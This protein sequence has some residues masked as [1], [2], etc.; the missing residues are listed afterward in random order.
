MASA[1]VTVSC[2]TG[3][4]TAT[5]GTDG[6]FSVSITGGALP[7]VLTATS[8]DKSLE[9]HSLIP[10]TSSGSASATA[11]ITPLSELLIAKYAGTDPKAFVTGFT[12]T[13]AIK[14]SDITTAQTALLNTL[15]TAGVD[16]SKAADILAGTIVAGSK[17]DYDGVLEQLKTT[18]TN[19]GATLTDLSSAVQNSS[20]SS[21]TTT[22]AT[23]A[24]L[25][26]PAASDCPGL[27]T[28][29]LRVVNFNTTDPAQASYQVSVDAAALTATVGS[30]QYVLSKNAACD[31]TAKAPGATDTRVLVSRSGMAVLLQTG[32][33]SGVA[34][35]DQ[36]LDI[37]SLAGSYNRVNFSKG[38]DTF[39]GDFGVTK[40]RAGGYNGPADGSDNGIYNCP[41]GYGACTADTQ[42]KGT[43]KANTAGG[44]DY[45][46]PT[47]VTSTRGFAFRSAAGRTFI[48]G[49]DPSSGAVSVLT[50]QDK[51]P[52]PAVGKASSFWQFTVKP[53]TGVSAVTE[54][55]NTVTKVDATA[56][57][58]TRQYSATTNDG[59]FDTLAFNPVDATSLSFA[60]ARY[61]DPKL[62]TDSLGAAYTK[63]SSAI[64]LPFE[65]I[66]VTVSTVNTN[67][68]MSVSIDKP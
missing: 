67:R 23:L 37:A 14:A 62:C 32:G 40:F 25:L 66:V 59:H 44:F 31:Y 55:A 41:S 43:L 2:A 48:L 8:S 20:K 57:A 15:K 65:G 38:F 16:T 10:G 54:D 24:T 63:C 42:K 61:R 39:I 7:C 51:L 29:K 60:G 34:I 52:L 9:L 35:P 3:S 45:V 4:T 19:A 12:A 22:G 21:D 53:A 49:W 36:Q 26:A 6:K 13:T 17:T 33:V 1:A 28:G 64:Q 47:G 46:E 27:K 50:S 5:T 11:N 56:G 68:F 18:L 58:V 30:T